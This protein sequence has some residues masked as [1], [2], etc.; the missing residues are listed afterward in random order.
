MR[1]GGDLDCVYMLLVLLHT[2][3]CRLSFRHT[4]GSRYPDNL[5]IPA[6]TMPE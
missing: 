4:G 5:W 6:R 1:H 3:W 2:N